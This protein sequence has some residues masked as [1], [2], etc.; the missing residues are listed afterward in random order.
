MPIQRTSRD[1]FRAHLEA[2]GLKSGARICVHSRLI[3]FGYLAAGV[4]GVLVDLRDIV[5]PN[6][7][8][9][10][11]TFTLNIREGDIFDPATTPPDRVGALSNKLW[12][13]PGAVRS[14][15]PVHSYAAIGRDAD[16]MTSADPCSSL[17]DGS[18]FDLMQREEYV[19]LLLGCTFTEGATFAHHIEAE[20]GVPYRE[21]VALPRQLRCGSG[22]VK[23]IGVRYYAR[24]GDLEG[25]NDLSLIEAA[26][27]CRETGT[28]VPVPGSAR[29]SMMLGLDFLADVVRDVIRRN[30]YAMFRLKQ[31]A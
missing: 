12:Q 31:E 3:S 1:E 27:R 13:V 11:P 25:A 19:L 17:G 8:I 28:V 9:A 7:T 20:V 15:C 22:E 23:N 14:R 2:L 24:R 18:V 30:P 6:G 4:E 10:A 16:L 5:G 29:Q 26:A 21:W